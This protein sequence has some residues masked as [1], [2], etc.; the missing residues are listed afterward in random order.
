MSNVKNDAPFAAGDRVALRSHPAARGEV[1]S[2]ESRPNLS[3]YGQRW[4]V[5]VCLDGETEVCGRRKAWDW[6]SEVPLVEY[7][8]KPAVERLEIELARHDWYC[9][10]SDSYGVTLAGERHMSEMTELARE[11]DPEVVRRL[12]KA[13]APKG[14]SIPKRALVKD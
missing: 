13:A 4:F 14:F 5:E 3:G 8:N 11:C 10:M 12:W 6:M 9:H 2:V 7:E 1:L